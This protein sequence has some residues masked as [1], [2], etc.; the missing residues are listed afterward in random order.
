[1]PAARLQTPN[2]YERKHGIIRDTDVEIRNF[3]FELDRYKWLWISI[4]IC[5][6][7]LARSFR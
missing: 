4:P 5:V 7:N 3:V 2:I 1:M 6:K